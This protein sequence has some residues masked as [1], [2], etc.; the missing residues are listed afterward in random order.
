LI[1]AVDDCRAWNKE[2][3]L[4]NKKHY[5]M[6]SRFTHGRA[7]KYAQKYGAKCHFNEVKVPVEEYLEKLDGKFEFPE[8]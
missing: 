8:D 6:F 2:N 7:V 3:M 4:V 1:L 5:T